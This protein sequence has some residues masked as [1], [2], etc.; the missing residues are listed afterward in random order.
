M[1]KWEEIYTKEQLEA[2]QNIQLG[3]LKDFDKICKK[4]DIDY[5]VYGGTLIGAVKFNGFVPWDD[6]IDIAM[7]REDYD[8]LVDFCANN[9]LDMYYL[10]NP[11]SDKKSPFPYLKF[12]LKDTKYIE[13]GFHR[14]KMQ[15]GIYLD[16]YPIDKL[17]CNS[18]K[19]NDDFKSFQFWVRIFSRRQCFFVTDRN[20]KR[21]IFKAV[22]FLYALL[23]HIIPRSC[24]V[25]RIDYISKKGNALSDN[26]VYGNYY[27]K[28]P[29]NIFENIKPLQKVP[30]EDFEVNIPNDWEGFLTK[31]YGDYKQLPPPEKRIG[32]RPYIIDFGKYKNG[33]KDEFKI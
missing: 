11:Y 33:I 3:I 13:Y 25:K 12:R 15:Q 7:L 26:F 29:V 8:K 28:S 6:D 2:V 27:H 16:I 5:F 30:F 22:K 18:S 4:L 21:V 31:R 17:P 14:L 23:L 10:Q 20:E 1:E 19:R 32:H 24:I 9:S